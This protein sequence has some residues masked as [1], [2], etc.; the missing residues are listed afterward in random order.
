VFEVLKVGESYCESSAPV[1]RAITPYDQ[2]HFYTYASLL[3]A[4]RDGMDWC[5]VAQS[6]L[7]LDIDADP[8][9]A[10]LCWQSHFARARWLVR[11]GLMHLGIEDDR[12]D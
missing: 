1:E 11:E 9:A 4:E 10:H 5:S 8:D 6:V 2:R 7:H 12:A 3:S